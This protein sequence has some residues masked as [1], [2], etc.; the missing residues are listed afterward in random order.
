MVFCALDAFGGGPAAGLGVPE[1][2]APMALAWAG[3]F[4]KGFHLNHKAAE[5]RNPVDLFLVP[6]EVCHD[7]RH[8][9]LVGVA[10]LH[11]VNGDGLEALGC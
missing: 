11:P 9:G 1:F 7:E 5:L 8:G 10:L 3:L 6:G 4:V 2:L